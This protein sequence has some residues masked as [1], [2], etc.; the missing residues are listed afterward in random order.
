MYRITNR[1]GIH[2]LDNAHRTQQKW[3]KTQVWAVVVVVV[4]VEVEVE[5]EV[6]AAAAAAAAAVAA[7]VAGSL[8]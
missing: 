6:A 2:S 3:S 8:R 5:V 1:R 4:V 7:A